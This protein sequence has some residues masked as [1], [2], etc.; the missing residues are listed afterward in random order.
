MLKSP[1]RIIIID[2][3]I[4]YANRLQQSAK[5]H[6]LIA[7]CFNTL[8]E[9]IEALEQDISYKYVVL[10]DKCYIDNVK[11]GEPKLSFVLKAWQE[12]EDVM[13]E[14]DRII[15]FCIN[16]ADTKR[17]SDVF[18][19]TALVFNKQDLKSEQEMFQHI[20]AE[21][22]KQSYTFI[23]EQYDGAYAF[24][25]KHLSQTELVL[26]YTI[27]TDMKKSQ[28]GAIVGCMALLRRLEE[29]VF[30]KAFDAFRM[31]YGYT[32]SI[33]DGPNR[34]RTKSMIDMMYHQKAI[35][36]FVKNAAFNI[37]ST[38]SKYGNHSY[39]DQDGKHHLP[40]E[41]FVQ[42]LALSLFGVM[43]FLNASTLFE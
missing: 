1:Q 24:V 31:K 13:Q 15:D 14:H 12:L 17:V 28:R 5:K 6:R 11:E 37:Y 38:C 3:D 23:E 25:S 8:N 43:D 10:D 18:E 27:A 29:V 19:D 33:Y 35:P 21:I 20:V 4:A 39:H 22:R 9:A 2:D 16:A 32:K 40:S 41:Y 36:Y 42:S 7:D 26:F 30:D 34:S